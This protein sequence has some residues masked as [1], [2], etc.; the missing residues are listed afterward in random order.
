MYAIQ[1]TTGRW[2]QLPARGGVTA[3]SKRTDS[4]RHYRR[5]GDAARFMRKLQD[6][7][8]ADRWSVI[9]VHDIF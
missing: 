1:D 8:Q 2:L 7:W 5:K 4:R 6:T 9:D 3:W